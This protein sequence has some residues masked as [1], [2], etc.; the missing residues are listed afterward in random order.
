MNMII[1]KPG[2]SNKVSTKNYDVEF[3]IIRRYYIIFV[4]VMDPVVFW[5]LPRNL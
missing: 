2:V 3:V 1:Y 4:P 5:P